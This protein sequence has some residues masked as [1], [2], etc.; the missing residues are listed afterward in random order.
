MAIRL[1]ASSRQCSKSKEGLAIAYC[2]NLNH[3]AL[4]RAFHAKRRA[5]AALGMFGDPLGGLLFGGET[6]DYFGLAIGP[7]IDH[8]IRDYL[9]ASRKRIVFGHLANM[10]LR[11]AG[12]SRSSDNNQ[13]DLPQPAVDGNTAPAKPLVR[14]W[15]LRVRWYSRRQLAAS[16]RKSARR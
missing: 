15:L 16:I 5:L 10:H 8:P 1:R 9:F 2:D 7:N 12:S 13:T 6:L 11:R 4:S 14:A 3:P